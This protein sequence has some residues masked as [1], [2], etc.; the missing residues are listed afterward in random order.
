MYALGNLWI[1]EMFH[2]DAAVV[3]ECVDEVLDG[4]V[5]CQ[6]VDVACPAGDDAIGRFVC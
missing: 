1:D 6:R 3:L 2:D 5:A 4:T